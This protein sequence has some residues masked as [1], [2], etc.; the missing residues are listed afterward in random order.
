MG[1]VSSLL[2]R[3][4]LAGVGV[5]VG[6]QHGQDLGCKQRQVPPDAQ[7]ITRLPFLVDPRHLQP[8]RILL[9]LRLQFPLELSLLIPLIPLFHVLL[10]PFL[11]SAV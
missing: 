10:S 8:Y 11:K 6:R 2:P 4:S 3:L 1:Q 5:G 7:H 9:T